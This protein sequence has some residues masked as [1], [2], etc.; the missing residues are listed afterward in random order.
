MAPTRRHAEI[1][2]RYA[3]LDRGEVFVLVNDH[4]PRPLQYQFEAE[5]GGAYTWDYLE[6]GPKVWKVRIDRR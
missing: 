2:G 3:S 6:I 5:H 4:D 1:F